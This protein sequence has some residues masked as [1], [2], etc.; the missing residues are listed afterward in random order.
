MDLGLLLLVDAQRHG[1]EREHHAAQ[2]NDS[3]A[4]NQAVDLR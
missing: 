4:E 3:E 2:A 1:A